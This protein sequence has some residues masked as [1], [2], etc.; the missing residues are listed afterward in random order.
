[1][2]KVP[3]LSAREVV[4]RFEKLGYRVVRQRGSHIRMLHTSRDPI[5]VPNYKT[6]SRGLL[7]KILRDAHLSVSEFLKLR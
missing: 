5:T 2:P 1:M 7:H 3:I 4:K 6:I